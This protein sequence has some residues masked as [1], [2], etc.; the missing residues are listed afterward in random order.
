MRAQR[1]SAAKDPL[2]L[3]HPMDRVQNLLVEDLKRIRRERAAS[4]PRIIGWI[5]RSGDL[6]CARCVDATEAQRA[7]WVEAKPGT[8]CCV[9]CGCIPC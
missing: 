3:K 4:V 5:T 7:V 2:D 1:E 8:T 9:L 6:Y